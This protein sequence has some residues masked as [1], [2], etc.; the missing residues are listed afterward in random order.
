MN[1]LGTV[2]EGTTIKYQ[3][4]LPGPIETVWEYLT[5]PSY[6]SAWLADARMEHR[7]GGWVDLMFDVEAFPE[8]KNGGA[9]IVGVISEYAP[10]HAISYSWNDADHAESRSK[11]RMELE[12]ESDK[13][14]IKIT[15]EEL[16]PEQIAACSAGW[17]THVMILESVLKGEPP[18]AFNDLFKEIQQRYEQEKTLPPQ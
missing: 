10:P 14:R 18:R 1:Q 4:L 13:V 9:H 8:R 15:H 3:H 12:K 5:N 11:V 16:T 6:I 17:N 7:D 2:V